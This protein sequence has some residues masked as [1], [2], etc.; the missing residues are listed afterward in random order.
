MSG[1]NL[2]TETGY[3]DTGRWGIL[4]YFR[5]LTQ[6]IAIIADNGKT[7]NFQILERSLPSAKTGTSLIK[8]SIS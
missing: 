5:S 1:S 6:I 8:Q 2:G 4:D 7:A 3:L